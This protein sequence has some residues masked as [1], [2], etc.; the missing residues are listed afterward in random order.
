MVAYGGRLGRLL[1]GKSKHDVETERTVQAKCQYSV[2]TQTPKCHVCRNKR[3]ARDAG[4]RR[5][6][7]LIVHFGSSTKETFVLR[8][9]AFA[10][11]S[12]WQEL[13]KGGCK[14]WKARDDAA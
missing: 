9:A 8:M 2:G 12:A 10:A 6:P 1:E 7:D 5:R 4:W 3:C 11:L 14:A 13:S